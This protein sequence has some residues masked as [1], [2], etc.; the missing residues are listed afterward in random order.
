[1]SY[2]ELRS[3]SLKFINLPPRRAW[4]ELG[5]PFS[6]PFSHAVNFKSRCF[7]HPPPPPLP[8]LLFR[9]PFY[10]LFLDFLLPSFLPLSHLFEWRPGGWKTG[11]KHPRK[12][13]KS[14][15]A[16]CR[17]G[18]GFFLRKKRW[19]TA[20][21]CCKKE[22]VQACCSGSKQSVSVVSKKEESTVSFPP[23]PQIQ[24]FRAESIWGG[25]GGRGQSKSPLCLPPL[26]VSMAGG[27]KKV[28]LFFSR[29]PNNV[30]Y[31]GI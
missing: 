11:F 19:D 29:F 1:M 15:V 23:P 10:S 3:L 12:R 8:A 30:E 9:A 4:K 27:G 20:D 5:L 13:R 31:S 2:K 6:L 28:T 25:V 17:G 26:C 14:Q 24:F 18:E 16:F 22:T 21:S 7:P